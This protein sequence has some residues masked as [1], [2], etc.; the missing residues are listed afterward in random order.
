VPLQL[1]NDFVVR[2]DQEFPLIDF[3]SKETLFSNLFS[4]I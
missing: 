3:L 4:K 1:Q 2:L